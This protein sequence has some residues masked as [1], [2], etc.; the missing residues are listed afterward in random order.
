ML[1]SLPENLQELSL[2]WNGLNAEGAAILARRLPHLK[3]LRSISLCGNPIGVEGLRV[4]L[5]EGKIH[6]IPNVDLWD[7]GIGDEGASMLGS[8]LSQPGDA[9]IQGLVLD[10]NGIGDEGM[11][12]LSD[13]LAKNGI[14]KSLRLYCNEIGDEGV[15][16]LMYVIS[17]GISVLDDLSLRANHIGP[18]GAEEI[19][20]R[21]HRTCL[22]KLYLARNSI[23]DVGAQYLANVL[24]GTN[25]KSQK[26]GE[27]TLSFNQLS[28]KGIC[29]MATALSTNT[30][31]QRLALDG[32]LGVDR[33][34]ASCFVKSCL[35]QNKTLLELD[36]LENTY[37]NHLLN[38]K[39]AFYLEA[40]RRGRQY[41]GDV[42]IPNAAWPRIFAA[43]ERPDHLFLFL[44]ERPDIACNRDCNYN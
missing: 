37:D 25:I 5:D 21:L 27:L 14:L 13:G 12:A 18:S 17:N 32:N 35:Q 42:Q 34:G 26:L 1:L 28:N 39:L 44:K 3:K 23:G 8:A 33:R 24:D 30:R 9:R 6:R 19:A 31:L 22:K 43:M 15:H 2:S 16:A 29:A 7:C 4:L 36:I 11:K 20:R 38:D 41:V 40:N 10:M